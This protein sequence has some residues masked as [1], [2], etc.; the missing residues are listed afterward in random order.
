MALPRYA[1]SSHERQHM[2]PTR[3]WPTHPA[4]AADRD[5]PRA[6][7]IRQPTFAD[8]ELVPDATREEGHACARPVQPRGP[9]L[10]AEHA[11]HSITWSARASSVG[12]IVSP[13][14][15]AVLR[16]ITSSNLVGCATGKVAGL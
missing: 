9:C 13:R 3:A 15:L 8:G 11:D 10:A 6:G 5:R 1:C 16:L 7:S 12:G 2:R 4:F 14:A